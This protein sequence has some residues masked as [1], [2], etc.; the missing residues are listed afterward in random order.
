MAT[1]TALVAREAEGARLDRALQDA[2]R[3]R[4]GLLLL[5]GEAGV[6]KTRLAEE[7]AGGASG[8]VLAGRARQ[9]AAAAYGPVVAALRSLLR[10]RPDALDGCGPLR[11]HLALILPELGDPAPA[12]DGATLVEAVHAALAHIARDAPALV[13]LDDLQWS[14]DATIA[15][16][17]TLAE[18]LGR[19]PVLVVAGYRS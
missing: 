15:L 12:G 1:R 16:L 6:G 9:G 10:G 7:L 18:P 11:P 3:G 4:G 14:D 19:L 8:P 5:S 13:L 17:A 2:G